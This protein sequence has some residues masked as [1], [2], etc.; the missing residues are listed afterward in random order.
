MW[1]SFDISVMDGAILAWKGSAKNPN[2]FELASSMKGHTSAVICLTIGRNRLYSGSVDNTIR[3]WDLDTLQCVHTL[4]GHNDAVTSLIC[5]DQ[6]L[7]SCSLDK[8][9]KAWA[10]TEEGN[11][12]VI[13]THNEEHG[14]IALCGMPDAEAK[15]IL[16]CSCSDNT[17]YLYEL[18]TF[19]ERGR[20]FSK[21]EVRTIQTGPGEIVEL[22]GPDP[23]FC[24]GAKTVLKESD[25]E[26]GVEN[27]KAESA[28]LPPSEGVPETTGKEE[29]AADGHDAVNT[30]QASVEDLNTDDAEKKEESEK[31]SE[32]DED[33][34]TDTQTASRKMEVPNDKVGLIIGRG[35]DAIKALQAKSGARIQLIP[36]HLPEG[37]GSKE[38]TVRVTGDRKQIEMAREMIKDVMNQTVRSSPYSGSFNQQHSYR[39]RGPTGPSNWGPRGPHSSQPNPYDYHLRGPYP[40]QSSQYP[41]PSYGGYP[42]QQMGPEGGHVSDHPASGPISTP[43][44]GHAPSPSPTPAMSHSPSQANYNYGQPHGPDYGHQAPYSQAVPSQQGYGHGYDEPKYDNHAPMQHPYG[45]GS[46]QPVYPQASNQPGYRAQQQYGK[47]PSCGMP[48]QGPPPQSYGPP[49]PSQPGDM[50][51]QGPIQSSQSYGPNVPPQ[52]QYPYASSGQSY[53]SNGS[54]SGAE[55]NNQAMPTSGPGYP[56]QEQP[57]SN[58]AGYGYQGSQDPAYGSGPGATYSAPPSGQQAYAQPTATQ[59][60]YDQS[61]PQSGA[62]GAAPGSAPVGI[63]LKFEAN[64]VTVGWFSKRKRPNPG[65]SLASNSRGGGGGSEYKCTRESSSSGTKAMNLEK[66]KPSSNSS[67]LVVEGNASEEKTVECSKKACENWMSDKCDKEDGCQFL[68]SWFYGD[69]FSTL[70]KLKGHIQAVSGIALP[71]RSDKL[72]S[73]GSD[74][75]VHVWDCNT[76]QSTRVINV[77][78]KIGALISEGPWIFV[79]LPNIV[80]AWNIETAAEF[81]L[82]GPVGQVNAIAVADVVDMLFAGA[83]DGAIL[84]WKGSAKNP[85]PFELASSMKGHTSAVICL[86]IG[87]N[88]LYSGSVDNTIRGAIALCG[89]PDAEAKPILLCSCSDNTVY[90]YELPTFIERGRIFSKSEVRTIQTGPGEIVELRGPDPS[91]CDGA[92]TVLKE[93]DEEPG[94]ENEKA[95]SAALPPS[96]GVPETTGKE[97]PAADGHD[98]V[99]TQQASV[100]DLNTDDAEKKEESENILRRTRIPLGFLLERVEILFVTCRLQYN[101]GAKIQI[102]RDADA[103]PQSTTRPVEIIGTLSN[104]KKAEKLI[105]A[106]IAEVGLIIGRG[107]D[108]IKAL[109][110]KSGARIQLIPQHLPEGDGS[111]ER[112][113]RVTGDRKQIEMAREMIKDVM[114]Q[115]VRSSPYSGSFNQQHS[116]RPRGPTGPSNWGPRGPHSSQ[117]NPYDYHHRGPYPSQSSQ[118][119]PP[120][121][122]GYPPNK[123]AQ[124]GGHVS[125]HPA[126]GPISTPVSGHAPSPSP[127]PA[128]SHSPSQANYNYGQPHGPDYGHQAPYSQAVP[129]QQGYGHGYDEP[130]YDNHAPMQHPYGHGSSQP[131]YPQASNQPGYRAQQQYGKQPSYGTP[132]QGP[133]PQSYG[134]SRPSQPGDMPYQ[135]PIQSSQSYGP[136]VPPQQQYPYA[137]SGQS[138]PSNGS[139]QEL[140]EQLGN[141]YFWPACPRQ[142]SHPF[143]L[144]SAWWTT[145]NW[146]CARS[147]RWLWII[148]IFTTSYPEQPASNNAG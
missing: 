112:T 64:G 9:I 11:L 74:G 116:Y 130:K 106:V 39:P 98:A 10:F 113:V 89:M 15:P 33:P 63:A 91:F 18:P 136:N 92:K 83:Q 60:S 37:D 81:N 55:G 66:I 119:P 23:S 57:A 42:P 97:E 129:S 141:A 67:V 87:R 142:G 139:H 20:I 79:G 115:T 77:G 76:G 86:T 140:R 14:A 135:G 13:Y 124:E 5:W 58:N 144:S 71:S 93:S 147:N 102:T 88:R 94:V 145:V 48:L 56:Q 1:I 103:N 30:Q 123:W 54:A 47:Q 22:R 105:N 75:T 52:Q 7:L 80:K 82:D 50:P 90:L 59:P 2:P 146:L 118:Y 114:N 122:G 25:E 84:A 6:Y 110:A 45:H 4:S 73:S 101:S 96:E 133:P 35:G 8:T 16:L 24:D 51:Y 26:P 3:A 40:S 107:G 120:S 53:P 104:I 121:Y 44:S 137:S 31:H 143:V 78:V 100:E 117:P 28:A 17:V 36:Q 65:N 127:T 99:N 131:V 43:V 62:Y 21:S 38:R 49:R 19:I 41:P 70:A 69:W 32:E 125:D 148:P 132:L 61:V 134:P 68:H 85:N 138:Y 95:E 12:D 34:V 109:Q 46:S 29:P 27:E 108:A 126:S 72:F 128:M 111:K